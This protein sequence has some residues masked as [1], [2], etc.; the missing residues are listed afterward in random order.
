[1][2]E[3]PPQGEA[4]EPGTGRS[5]QAQILCGIA[6]K[7]NGGLSNRV[8]VQLFFPE[9]VAMEGRGDTKELLF[10]A[11]GEAVVRIWSELPQA[12]QQHLFEQAVM[13]QGES[14][15]QELAVFLHDKHVRTSDAMRARAMLEPD[16]LGG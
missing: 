9:E 10:R 11:L 1:M 5:R 3:Q 4:G 16:S 14:V 2:P 12:V 6:P 13:A 15:R 7:T 8:G